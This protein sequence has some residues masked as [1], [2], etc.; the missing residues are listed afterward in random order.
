MLLT[1]PMCDVTRVANVAIF[2]INDA[3]NVH[4]FKKNCKDCKNCKNRNNIRTFACPSCELEYMFS[5]HPFYSCVLLDIVQGGQN[6]Q[7]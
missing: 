2:L 5:E 7:Q 4:C 1:L 6:G 3:N